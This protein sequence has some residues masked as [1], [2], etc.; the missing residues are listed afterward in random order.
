MANAE[1]ENM[2]ERIRVGRD[3]FTRDVLEV[4]PELL[5]MVLVVRSADNSIRRF[6]I[7]ETEAY[8]GE[9]DRACHA[10]RGRTP[11]TEIMYHVGGNLYIYLVYGMYWMLNI[12]TGVINDPQAVLIRGIRSFYGPGRVTRELGI[13]RSFYG[14]DLTTSDRIWL[15]E[16][17]GKT[18]FRTGT[19]IGIDYAGDYWKSRPWR[20]FLL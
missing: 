6:G 16:S 4:A 11:R 18:D 7:T 8:R 15:E 12:V 14:V 3:F 5:S 13:N 20:Y 1:I 10:W 9:E 2:N 17:G 19:R